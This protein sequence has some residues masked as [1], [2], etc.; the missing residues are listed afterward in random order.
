MPDAHA[1]G[2]D[3]PEGGLLE[4]RV[5]MATEK[6]FV[7]L[8]RGWRERP[9]LREPSVDPGGRIRPKGALTT[10]GVDDQSGQLVAFH[11]ALVGVGFTAQPKRLVPNYTVD[12]ETHVIADSLVIAEKA[13]NDLSHIRTCRP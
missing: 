5:Q 7:T 4:C 10:A 11:F 1:L 9:S 6:T 2:S 13:P 12:S 3:L 8:A